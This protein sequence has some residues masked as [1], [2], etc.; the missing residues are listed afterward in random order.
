VDFK[1]I[2]KIFAFT[3]VVKQKSIGYFEKSTDCFSENLNR[4]LLSGFSVLNYPNNFWFFV[5]TVLTI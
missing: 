4:I 1:L 2:W 3:F 5:V